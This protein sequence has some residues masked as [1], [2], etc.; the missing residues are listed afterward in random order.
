MAA[1]QR[2]DFERRLLA[3]VRSSLDYLD[4]WY[5]EGWEIEHFVLTFRY[6]RPDEGPLEPWDGGRYVGMF[7]SGFTTSSAGSYE[8]DEWLLREALAHTQRRREE[9]DSGD[10]SDD[11]DDADETETN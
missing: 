11:E 10:D 9:S 6:Y 8:V 2:E 3:K 7:S 4:E 1:E 5:P